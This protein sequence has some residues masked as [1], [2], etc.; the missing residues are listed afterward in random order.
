MSVL[1]V[2][3]HAVLFCSLSRQAFATSFDA[4]ACSRDKQDCATE[5][6]CAKFDEGVAFCRYCSKEVCTSLRYS[7]SEKTACRCEHTKSCSVSKQDCP[8]GNFCHRDGADDGHCNACSS[9]HGGVAVCDIP[10][11]RGA[12]KCSIASE[13]NSTMTTTQKTDTLDVLETSASGV[14]QSSVLHSFLAITLSCLAFCWSE[15][16]K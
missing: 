11:A 16:F 10:E 3:F 15:S 4:E 2:G 1:S 5:L 9:K 7:V 8:T 12:C 13:G 14:K 6:Y